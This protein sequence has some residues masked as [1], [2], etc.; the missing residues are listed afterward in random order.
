[1][2]LLFISDLHLAPERPQVTDALYHFIEAH[3][4][5]AQELY[6]LGDLF[7][8]WIGDDDPSDFA[9]DVQNRI[10]ELSASGTKVYIQHGNRDFLLDR[11]F[12]RRTGAT[13]LPDRH[14]VKD[15]G[16]SVLLMHGDLLCT[17]DIPYQRFRRK[18][19]NPL[20]RWILAH[21]PLYRRQKIAADW[22]H[23]SNQANSNKASAIMDVNQ[24]T[25]QR[26]MDEEGVESLIHGHTH[27]PD[28]HAYDNGQKERIVLGDWDKLGW[29]V[30]IEGG[31]LEL[32]S[33]TIASG[34][35]DAVSAI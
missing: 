24:L 21:L 12:M 6:I 4:Q 5:Y 22:R 14:V 33:F 19:R 8:V 16:K 17:D 27:R 1:M 13:L 28:R 32:Y 15:D 30:R 10:G 18:V 23:K 35:A 31:A 34:G 20:Y 26:V 7:E 25:V 9:L 11:R 29:A 2:S 3:A